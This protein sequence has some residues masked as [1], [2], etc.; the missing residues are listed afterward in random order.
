M[1]TK[2]EDR[3]E[4]KVLLD[5]AG[6]S[7]ADLH[8]WVARG[9][10]PAYCARYAGPGPGSEYYYPIEALDR[11]RAIKCLRHQGMSMQKIRKVLA[12]VVIKV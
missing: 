12:R 11:A 10:L 1:T 4:M 9:L 6:I 5:L 2:T 8:H 7:S 3:I